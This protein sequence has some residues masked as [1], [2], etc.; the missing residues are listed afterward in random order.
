[1]RKNK[2]IPKILGS[3]FVSATVI[4]TVIFVVLVLFINTLLG[5]K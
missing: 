4:N 2:G 3:A 1:M 5:M